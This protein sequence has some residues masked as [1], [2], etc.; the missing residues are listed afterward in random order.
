MSEFDRKTEISENVFSICPQ[1]ATQ[2]FEPGTILGRFYTVQRTRVS[3]QSE[4]VWILG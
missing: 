4:T 2:S 3:R 1:L